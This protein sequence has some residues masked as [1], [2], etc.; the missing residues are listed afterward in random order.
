MSD[1]LIRMWIYWQ[2]K[3]YLVAKWKSLYSVH[4]IFQ[5]ILIISEN[6]IH[7]FKM[8]MNPVP[9]SKSIWSHKKARTWRQKLLF[10]KRVTLLAYCL[11]R[12]SCLLHYVICKTRSVF[13]SRTAWRRLRGS[14]SVLQPS[15]S[16]LTQKP[17]TAETDLISGTSGHHDTCW[18]QKAYINT[19]TQKAKGATKGW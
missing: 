6:F 19:H 5:N 8:K 10:G 4:K 1:K 3:M 9:F 15:Q 11:H 18:E 16:S 2:G 7:K 13:C 14:L 17:L 12:W